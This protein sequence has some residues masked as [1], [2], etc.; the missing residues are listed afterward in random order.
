MWKNKIIVFLRDFITIINISLYVLKGFLNIPLFMILIVSNILL[1]FFANKKQFINLFSGRKLLLLL[2]I[3]LIMFFVFLAFALGY[4]DIT[5]YRFVEHFRIYFLIFITIYYIDCNDSN[6][7]KFLSFIPL[8]VLVGLS[9]YT[10]H[11][12]KLYPT[13]SRL[14]ATG[15]DMSTKYPGV[16][17]KFILSYDLIYGMVFLC[18]YYIY[19]IRKSKYMLLNIPLLILFTYTIYKASFTIALIIYAFGILCILIYKKHLYIFLFIIVVMILARKPIANIIYSFYDKIAPWIGVR[20]KQLADL[21]SGN[22][23]QNDEIY[24]RLTRIILSFDT[25]LKNPIIGVGAFY[26]SKNMAI[27]NIGGHSSLA[28]LFARY[29]FP[30]G[31]LIISLY[32]NLIKVLNSSNMRIVSCLFIPLV[33]LSILNPVYY[34]SLMAFIL[35]IIPIIHKNTFLIIKE[36]DAQ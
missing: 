27:N 31:I 26:E 34:S 36:K 11:M 32:G 6:Y 15:N 9:I 8:I 13:I 29:G 16:N 35:F 14:M 23:N 28:D 1:L 18:L 3:C 33:A 17:T 4:G 19:S 10:I 25:S 30:F 24:D 12:L 5:I 20:L 7:F 2:Q 22:L 21:I